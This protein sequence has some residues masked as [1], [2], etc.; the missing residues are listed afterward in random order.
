MCSF[1]NNVKADYLSDFELKSSLNYRS[2]Y[3]IMSNSPLE[4]QTMSINDNSILYSVI[5]RDKKCLI[6]GKDTTETEL[7]IKIRN[8]NKLL[9]SDNLYTICFDCINQN[10][11]Y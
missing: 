11:V 6:C 9:L 3:Q 7:T 1:C 5:Q 2:H 10:S 4:I 8:I